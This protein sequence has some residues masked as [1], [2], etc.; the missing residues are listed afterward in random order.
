M[1]PT[2]AT[3]AAIWRTMQ[4]PGRSL[5]D[6]FIEQCLQAFTGAFSLLPLQLGWRMLAQVANA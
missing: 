2:S 3:T 5:Q 4:N 6:L 1:N